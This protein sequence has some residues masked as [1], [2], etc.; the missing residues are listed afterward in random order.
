MYSSLLKIDVLAEEPGGARIALQTDHRER[1][2]IEA[3]PEVSV[4]LALSR[5]LVPRHMM[6]EQGTPL[7]DVVYVAFADP[8]PFLVEA[9]GAVGAL[10]ERPPSGARTRPASGT[11]TVESV[12]E[13]GFTDLAV[14]VQRRVQLSDPAMVLRALE[15][16]TLADPPNP[17]DDEAAYWTRVLELMA[18]VVAVMRIRHAGSWQVSTSGLSDVPFQFTLAGQQALLPG[19]RAAR[20]IADGESESMFLLLVS[21]DELVA[22]S[23]AGKPTGPL[24]PSLRSRQ[25]ALASGLLSRP[26]LDGDQPDVPVIVYGNDGEHTFGLLR[27]AEAE[28]RAEAIHTEAMANVAGIAAEVDEVAVGGLRMLSVTGSFFAT[29]KLLDPPF[30]RGLAR[31]LGAELLAV[32]VPRR[33]LL[34]ATSGVQGPAEIADLMRIVEHE[35][36]TGGGRGISPAVL[37]VQDGMPVG[38]ARAAPAPEVPEAEAPAP[39]RRGWFARLFGRR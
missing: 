32:G 13:R 16:E 35:F 29:E 9:L 38:F 31:R 14:R 21:V 5:V 12:L 15:A 30:L 6:Q 23:A 8:P 33:G 7:A 3:E 24:L 27:R 19:N 1:A 26:L 4:L 10:L 18:C 17:E 34:L 37:L 22:S 39:K 2:E 36:T 20:L 25:E 28:P 11:A